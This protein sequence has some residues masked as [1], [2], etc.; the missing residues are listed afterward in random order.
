MPN[1]ASLQAFARDLP[2][3][4]N[5]LTLE[6]CVCST[7]A[8][9]SQIDVTSRWQTLRMSSLHHPF[10]NFLISFITRLDPLNLFMYMCF[11][12]RFS[13]TGVKAPRK[14]DSIY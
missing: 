14:Q 4:R 9:R 5:P 1:H 2:V 7:P 10:L 11:I 13:V 3:A 8:P 12:T 6:F